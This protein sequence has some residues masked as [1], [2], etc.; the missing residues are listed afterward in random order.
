MALELPEH[1]P[2][3]VLQLGE[4]RSVYRATKTTLW[5]VAIWGVLGC[6]MGG[7]IMIVPL[8]EMAGVHNA[9]LRRS[10]EITSLIIG[11]LLFGASLWALVRVLGRRNVVVLVCR[12]GFAR[13]L[14]GQALIW[15]WDEIE[16]L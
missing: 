6:A 2:A 10:V 11:S 16:S 3:E 5:Q 9:G 8:L 13:L 15:R 14:R 12:D 4:P 7:A 1:V